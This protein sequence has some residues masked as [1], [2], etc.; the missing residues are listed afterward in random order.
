MSGFKE[1]AVRR[2]STLESLWRL[3]PEWKALCEK[4]PCSTPFQRP[5]WLLPWIESFRP[6]DLWV[7]EVRDHEKLVGIAPLFAYNSRDDERTLA[8]MGGGISDY[9]DFIVDPERPEAV[10]QATCDF[11]QSAKPDWDKIELLDL[12]TESALLHINLG[13][14]WTMRKDEHDVC[15][16]LVLPSGAHQL[17]QVIPGR[18]NRNLRT[19]ANR[20]RR[21]GQVHVTVADEAT[22]TEHLDALLTLH[23]S[24]WRESGKPGVLANSRVREFHRRAAPLLREAGVLRLY[25]LRLDNQLIA[26]LYTLWDR[27][28]V[29]LYLQGFD[30]VY[31]DA[32][33][34]MQIVAAVVE[35][36]LRESREAI[37]FL[38]GREAYKYTWGARDEATFRVVLRNSNQSQRAP[39]ADV[40]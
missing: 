16:R 12:R 17:R 14:D 29:Y 32:S 15:P 5:E 28:V 37:D 20:M 27:N 24:R 23:G 8:I 18:Q 21:S 38:R 6:H 2:L 35:D 4:Q 34:G 30:P 19:A 7:I 11:L 10:L 22:M 36:A 25:G 33:P 26:A 39:H 3:Q 1:M 13:N 31:A 9:L 40:A